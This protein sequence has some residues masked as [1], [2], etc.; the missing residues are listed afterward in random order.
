MRT[1]PMKRSRSNACATQFRRRR[2]PDNTGFQIDKP[3]AQRLAVFVGF[4][5]KA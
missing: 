1:T 4:L 2:L 3:V 5:H